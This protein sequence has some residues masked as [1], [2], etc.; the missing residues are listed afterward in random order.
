[1]NDGAVQSSLPLPAASPGWVLAGIGDFDGNGT[2]DLLWRN[3]ASPGDFWIYL[4]N[5]TSVGGGGYIGVGPGYRPTYI[6]DFDGDGKADILWEK[7]PAGRWITFMA[8]AAARAFAPVPQASPGWQIAGAGDFNG[9]GRAD[10]LWMDTANPSQYWIYLLDGS[11]LIG[12]APL[13]AE[14]PQYAN[15]QPYRPRWIFDYDGD[16]KADIA[17]FRPSNGTW[18]IVNSSTGAA[19]GIQWGNGQDV[20][21]PGD[22][23][24]DVKT[25]V[26]VFRPSNGTWFL[27]Y[28]SSGATAG[29]QWGNGQDVTVPGD[30]D[31]DGKIDIAVFRPS[32][33]TWFIVNSST[34]TTTGI[35]WGNGADIPIF[36]R[37]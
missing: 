4:M 9:D 16:G 13:F 5:G 23:D 8:G 26:A 3:V 24:G 11:A 1:V 18:F 2:K 15:V 22:Y 21:V 36:K 20:I 7:H 34:G 37:P 32:N 14:A 28:S 6:A 17:V 29:I 33:G 10:L 27:M 30:Y 35:Q 19:A 12:N 25:D 31:G